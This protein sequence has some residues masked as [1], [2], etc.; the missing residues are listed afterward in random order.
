V[1]NKKIYLGVFKSGEDAY[2][3]YCKAAT[4]LHGAFNPCSADAPRWLPQS[5]G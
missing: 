3:A 2:A 5:Q 1:D 4:E